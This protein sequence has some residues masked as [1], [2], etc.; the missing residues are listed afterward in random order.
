[1]FNN[2]LYKYS[3]S[4]SLYLVNSSFLK[5]CVQMWKYNRKPDLQR[6]KEIKKDILECGIV[7][8]IIYIAECNEESNITYVC[9]D[10]NHRRLALNDIEKEYDVLVHLM[11]KADYEMIKEKFV[12]LNMANPVPELYLEED[13]NG[14]EHIKNIC[15]DVVKDLCKLFP[16]NISTSKN[17]RRPN[18][19]RD[20]IVDQLGKLLLEKRLFSISSDIIIKKIIQLNIQYM[21]GKGCSLDKISKNI[22][23][24]CKKTRC[25]LFLKNF[26][27]DLD[28]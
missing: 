1:M 27:D 19:N 11:I 25:Y 9:Y 3:S 6:V 22:L 16:K 7:D 18:F 17:P 5:N 28:L 4:E 24:K 21:S 2:L 23:E 20:N 14:I 15:N 8:G 10:G 12:K 26:C 13:T